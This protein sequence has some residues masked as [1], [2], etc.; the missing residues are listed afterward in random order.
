MVVAKGLATLL[1][2][3][4]VASYSKMASD[5]EEVQQRHIQIGMGF[6]PSPVAPTIT[7]EQARFE[8]P[9]ALLM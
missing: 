3:T 7:G 4:C 8:V 9:L 1:A 6:L 5:Q 2:P